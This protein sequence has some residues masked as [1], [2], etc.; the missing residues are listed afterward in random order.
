VKDMKKNI[1]YARTY[2]YLAQSK[3]RVL[4]SIIVAALPLSVVTFFCYPQITAMITHIAQYILQGYYAPGELLANHSNLIDWVGEITYV[5]IQG[6]YPTVLFNWFNLL[7][8]LIA[9]VLLTT[10]VKVRPWSI[11]ATVMLFV[12]LFSSLFFVFVP[13][14]FPYTAS[15]YSSLYLK[16]QMLMLFFTPFIMGSSVAILPCNIFLVLGSVISCYAY[17][18][19]FSVIRYVI[20][21]YILSKVSILYMA[22]LFFTFG[23]F[24]DFL[25]I[26]AIYSLVVNK[27]GNGLERAEAV[28]KW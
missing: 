2:R 12:H 1:T 19:V 26:V 27:V 3:W 22:S 17:F 28:W 25:Y 18:L 23:P 14:L 10:V 5:G 9:L 20:F 16:Q 21:L 7:F 11:F 13:W 6:R 15:E 8:T 24:I 4:F